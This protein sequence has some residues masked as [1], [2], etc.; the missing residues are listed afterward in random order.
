ML[1]LEIEASKS[2][3]NDLKFGHRH[4]NDHFCMTLGGHPFFL[5]WNQVDLILRKSGQPFFWA[6]VFQIRAI[7][8][9]QSD[10]QKQLN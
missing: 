2:P 1:G 8:K 3:T 10:S 6:L 7:L 5:P 9:N 4:R